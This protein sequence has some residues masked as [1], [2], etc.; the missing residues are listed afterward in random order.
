MFKLDNYLEK[1]SLN[2][3]LQRPNTRNTSELLH[4]SNGTVDVRRQILL[5]CNILL[6]TDIHT[7]SCG[8]LDLT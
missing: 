4:N 8:V 7:E 6:V 3:L 2:V 5:L 1:C